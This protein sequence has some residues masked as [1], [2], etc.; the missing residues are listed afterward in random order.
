MHI[1][2]DRKTSRGSSNHTYTPCVDNGAEP[3]VPCGEP[4]NI[5]TE[6]MGQFLIVHGVV[7]IFSNFTCDL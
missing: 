1:F 2:L 4:T 5:V 7:H 3:G 6:Q